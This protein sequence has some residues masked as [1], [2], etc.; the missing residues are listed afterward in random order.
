M[1]LP[2]KASRRV[3]ACGMPV[4]PESHIWGVTGG[5]GPRS[6]LP[7][8]KHL[9][10][11]GAGGTRSA[12]PAVDGYPTHRSQETSPASG[13]SIGHTGPRSDH[14]GAQQSQA[15]G[16]IGRTGDPHPR[17]GEAWS[18]GP[19]GTGARRPGPRARPLDLRP[20]GGPGRASAGTAW[21]GGA[22]GDRAP[23]DEQPG[24]TAPA[25]GGRAAAVAGGRG[26]GDPSHRA[27]D[28]ASESA[29]RS[30]RSAPAPPRD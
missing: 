26:P 8:P 17:S 27:G 16:A 28:A 25:A 29:R 4:V 9:R 1:G 10:H 14:R 24:R 20:H 23:G 22:A 11:R 3:F 13:R 30:A 21:D 18:H 7:S 15:R 6:N 19:G 2:V 5:G 12:L